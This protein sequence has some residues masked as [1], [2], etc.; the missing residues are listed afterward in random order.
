MN[1]I[2]DGCSVCLATAMLSPAVPRPALS[3]CGPH[4]MYTKEGLG[5][6]YNNMPGIL[7]MTCGML[8]CVCTLEVKACLS[9]LVKC[10]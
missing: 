7:R 4:K 10:V 9:Y 8:V 5:S 3:M 2:A 1:V 6:H